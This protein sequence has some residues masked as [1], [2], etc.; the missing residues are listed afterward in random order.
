LPREDEARYLADYLLTLGIST[1]LRRESAGWGV[2]V[3]DEDR[4]S[5]GVQELEAY[6]QNPDDPRFEAAPRTAEAIRRETERRDQEFRKNFHDVSDSWGTPQLR[7]R[8]VTFVLVVLSFIVFLLMN[9]P[10]R[11]NS[12]RVETEL[13]FSIDHVAAIQGK[14]VRV[15]GGLAEIKR[16]EVWR[17]VSPIFMHSDPLHL[18]L[19]MGALAYFAT[20]VEYRRGSLFLLLLV[21]VSAVVSNLGEYLYQVHS[22]GHCNLFRG[23]SG[24]ICALFG[25]IWMKGLQEPEA[26]LILSPSTVQFTLVFLVACIMDI[27]PNVANAA[28]LTGLG[29]GVVCGLARL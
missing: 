10:G 9:L 25:Y 18:L 16:G 17:L 19:N 6:R 28:H 7:R 2:W 29:F 4:L 15:P 14:F 20:M 3:L 24:V 26:G 23:M 22:F 13:A 8:P 21:L 27:I 1:Q 11:A 5:L 12:A